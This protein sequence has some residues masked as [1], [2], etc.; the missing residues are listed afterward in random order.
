VKN[1]VPIALLVFTLARCTKQP[2]AVIESRA[3]AVNRDTN[4]LMC[5]DLPPEPAVFG[6]TDSTV[7]L[8][9]NVTAFMYNPLNP[10]EAVVVVEGDITGYNKMFGYNFRTKALKYLA[11][12]DDHLPDIN[13]RGWIVYSSNDNN[14]YRIKANGDSARQITSFNRAYNA[15][16]DNTGYSFYYFQEAFQS[17]PVQIV[18]SDINGLPVGGF[19]AQLP[20]IAPFRKS[21]KV[22]YLAVLNNSVTL[23]QK[24]MTDQT[25]RHLISGPYQKSGEMHFQDLCV[26]HNDENVYWCNSKGIFRCRLTDLKVD[27][28]FKNCETVIYDNPIMSYKKGEMTY[29]AHTLKQLST[30]VLFHKFRPMELYYLSGERRTVKIFN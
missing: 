7:D 23:I 17:M 26:D 25:E 15:K 12:L 29:S 16:W 19:P 14:V 22:I 24:D 6:W 9:R 3:A 4:E 28:V 1:A 11:T 13:S 20:T 8:N 10:E 30:Y 2:A 27:T 5:R 18:R 21:D